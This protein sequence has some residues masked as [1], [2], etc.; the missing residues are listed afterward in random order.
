MSWSMSMDYTIPNRVSQLN[1]DIYM[2]PSQ[3]SLALMQRAD[4]TTP[5]AHGPEGASVRNLP[6]SPRGTNY[7]PT[8][9]PPPRSARRATALQR[10]VIPRLNPSNTAPSRPT[11]A[12]QQSHAQIR[13]AQ[14]FGGF[15]DAPGDTQADSQIYKHYTSIVVSHIGG[16][17][18]ISDS[19]GVVKADEV[20]RGN[21][22]IVNHWDQDILDNPT[23]PTSF[24]DDVDELSPDTQF[25]VQTTSPVK[26]M[27]PETPAM[28]GRKRN[29]RGEILSSATTKTPGSGLTTFFA[30]GAG[31]GGP[32]M[33]LTQLFNATQGA[34][35]PLLD[36]PRSDPVFQRPSPNFAHVRHSSPPATTSSPTKLLRSD[37]SRATTEPRDTYM[38]MKESQEL[39]ERRR[40]AE[41][42]FERLQTGSDDDW[43]NEPT[44]VEE[45]LARRRLKAKIDK[46]A[47]K[48]YAS[49]TAPSDDMLVNSRTKPMVISS[50]S[51]YITPARSSR[52]ARRAID[53]SDT[54]HE[55]ASEDG[56][57]DELGDLPPSTGKLRKLPAVQANG[58]QVP[59][60][61]SRPEK[62]SSGNQPQS[63]PSPESSIRRRRSYGSKLGEVVNSVSQPEYFSQSRLK[64]L[65]GTQTVAVADSQPENRTDP[66][67][68]PF[69]T[70][71]VEPLSLESDP[72]VSQSQLS[73]R[74]QR[75][76]PHSTLG[77]PPIPRPLVDSS[78]VIREHSQ[79][80]MPS[81][82]PMVFDEHSGGE[83]DHE[84]D[85]GANTDE[86][87]ELVGS[88]D[89]KGIADYDDASDTEEDTPTH[90]SP[91]RANNQTVQEEPT[92]ELSRIRVHSTI[93]E[94]DA[95]GE[96]ES[97]ILETSHINKSEAIAVHASTMSHSGVAQ[98][99]T[100]STEM[101]Q[102][103]R[104]QVSLSPQKI[105][106]SQDS[107]TKGQS[108][109]F[110]QIRRLTE[111]AADPE[112]QRSIN[113][114]DLDVGLITEE[115]DEF[116]KILS[117]SSPVQPV[118]K[119]RKVYSSKAL[120]SP[121]KQTN[122]LPT[123]TPPSVRKREDEGA[124]AAAQAREATVFSKPA[125]LKKGRLSRPTHKIQGKSSPSTNRAVPNAS[126]RPLEIA[127]T[128]QAKPSEIW[129]KKQ[130]PTHPPSPIEDS[131]EQTNVEQ[132]GIDVPQVDVPNLA[133]E[134]STASRG[135][136]SILESTNG[137]LT[138]DRVLAHFR[139]G[140]IAYYPA[141]CL[142][143]VEGT[144]LRIRF[145]DGTIDQLE[146]HNVRG[147]TLKIGDLVKVDLPK[148]RVK[149][150]VVAGFKDKITLGE[151]EFPCTDQHGYKTA[152]L[153][154]KPR[155]SLP[156][157]GVKNKVETVDV[158]ITSIYIT[159]TMWPRFKDRIYTHHPGPTVP[160]ISRLQTPSIDA[161][162][163]GTPKS[164]SRRESAINLGISMQR[165]TSVA[166]MMRNSGIF[167]NMAFAVSFTNQ[168][169]ERD[170]I[171]ALILTQGGQILEPGF[172]TL[173]QLPES[174]TPTN[175]ASPLRSPKKPRPGR[176]EL[177]TLT[178]EAADLGFVALIANTHS[179]RAKYIQA[180]ALN[181]PCLASRW[182]RDCIAQ[183]AVLPFQRYLLPAGASAF[184]GGVV[185]SRTMAPYDPVG[186]DARF[187][188]VLA[189][190]ELLLE[191]QNVLL[192][193]GKGKGREE[194]KRPYFF[195][196]HALGA[197][198][199]CWCRD[200][201]TAKEMLEGDIWDWVYVDGESRADAEGVLFDGH[202]GKEKGRRKKR[203][204]SEGFV[205]HGI[206]NG[207]R[208]KIAGDEFVVQ[209]LI[210]GA[211]IDE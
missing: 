37:P 151:E 161:S 158:P 54:V 121:V 114:A 88:D 107:P 145:D 137:L 115:F 56:S 191:A 103:A 128:P 143:F 183:G 65:S 15:A 68:F 38:T 41:A 125:V 159:S 75:L 153:G 61:S 165:T 98:A 24:V 199:V 208:V 146:S 22:D 63:S 197:R 49:L 148:M 90:S 60:T 157:S 8:K 84:V 57:T 12:D 32:S 126:H 62:T 104:S 164:R 122:Q 58:I 119:R 86:D 138:P 45:I 167:T 106:L 124:F 64:A 196:T 193:T 34:T 109:R 142:G 69:A 67:T 21:V 76:V 190:R 7:S 186:P 53:I 169:S 89:A 211:L 78:P 187:A 44:A 117:G 150:Y 85:V 185:R 152:V 127:E 206:V 23:S 118:K 171:S 102:T 120:R 200:L 87:M 144:N 174:P 172:T 1:D 95:A 162:M 139:G 5:L 204:S 79:E 43:D 39:R 92:G 180:L 52:R 25:R 192:V 101:Y 202:G 93:P 203:E 35:S 111:I 66:E 209:S 28:A 20:T 10:H 26:F 168:D 97:S 36:A 210:L 96:R 179:R 163:P 182:V 205:S 189:R 135:E 55:D 110:P 201:E 149:T 130:S 42:D 173:F 207:K 13:M 80:R 33:S 70:R 99:D 46:G 177:F 156:K 198:R 131:I 178:P 195:L 31:A 83:E 48:S 141:T 19:L 29:S 72:R 170:S 175:P 108:P 3:L 2:D 166:S 188:D 30:N 113:E 14:S 82:P 9:A 27:L 154:I 155:D 140:S 136:T 194:R 59:M 112:S 51:A 147:L 100:N 16:D 91:T 181:I 18:S 77:T 94:S 81:S 71:F 116:D 47:S 132:T 105:L 40:Q 50:D 176:D 184:L 123:G 17:N 133:P 134:P 4:E 11:A 6:K 160:N 73:N 129:N 74:S